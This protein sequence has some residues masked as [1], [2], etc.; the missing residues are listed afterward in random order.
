VLSIVAMG[1]TASSLIQPNKKRA[2]GPGRGVKLGNHNWTPGPGQ[3]TSS[4]SGCRVVENLEGVEE[5]VNHIEVL[6]TSGTTIDSA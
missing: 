5:V 2:K 4:G 1:M 3:Q 6:P